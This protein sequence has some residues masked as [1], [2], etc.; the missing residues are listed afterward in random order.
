M[1]LLLRLHTRSRVITF[2][3]SCSQQLVLTNFH[4]C[5]AAATL[6]N[7]FWWMACENEDF[8]Y[9]VNNEIFLLSIHQG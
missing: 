1:Y 9:F 5:R 4:F 2:I 7:I 3:S 6:R 8:Y